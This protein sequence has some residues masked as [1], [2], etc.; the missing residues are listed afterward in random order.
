MRL[1]VD[2]KRLRL[3]LRVRRVIHARNDLR[4]GKMVQVRSQLVEFCAR[5]LLLQFSLLEGGLPSKR[6]QL[7]A[8]F[9]VLS[10]DML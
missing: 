4:R 9:F 2:I 7:L 6:L 8:D 3:Q 10:L 1:D 5:R